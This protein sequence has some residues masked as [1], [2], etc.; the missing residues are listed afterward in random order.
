MCRATCGGRTSA[1][2]RRSGARS[3]FV[4]EAPAREVEEDV[5]ERRAPNKRA[6]YLH[7]ELVDALGGAVAVVG[8]EQQ[9]A[10]EGLD[11][12][13]E[14]VDP[15]REVI[16]RPLGREPQFDDFA[17]RVAADQ[18]LRRSLRDDLRLVHDDEPVAQLLRLV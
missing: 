17:C 10:A 18:L 7:A 3:S 1:R 6:L 4:D 8:V 5:L 11:A 14:A 12:T 13:C 9:P 16:R 15:I 2:T